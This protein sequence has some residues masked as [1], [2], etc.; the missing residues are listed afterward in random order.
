MFLLEE[1]FNSLRLWANFSI[2][3]VR[4][5]TLE[6]EAPGVNRSNCALNRAEK[7]IA[8]S[9]VEILSK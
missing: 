9:E 2:L 1:L 3:L 5:R 7:I 4:L 6:V 8:A